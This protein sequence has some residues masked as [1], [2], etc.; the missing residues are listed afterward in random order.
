MLGHPTDIYVRHLPQIVAASDDT[1]P[2]LPCRMES[3]RETLLLTYDNKHQRRRIESIPSHKILGYGSSIYLY[4]YDGADG[5]ERIRAEDSEGGGRTREVEIQIDELNEA[6]LVSKRTYDWS[7]DGVVTEEVRYEYDEHHRLSKST[8]FF[9]AGDAT[10][11][12]YIRYAYNDSGNLASIHQRRAVEDADDPDGRITFKYDANDRLISA[13]SG[14]DRTEMV[15]GMP[16]R[17]NAETYIFIYD[18]AD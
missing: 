13:T 9:N 8:L 15:M 7:G 17:H 12:H 10:P 16:T 1:A 5:L 14:T 11:D 2:D 6:G 3:Q 18:C 4:E